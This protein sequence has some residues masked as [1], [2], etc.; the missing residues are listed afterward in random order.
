VAGLALLGLG[1][2]HAAER[3]PEY[4]GPLVAFLSVETVRGQVNHVRDGDTIELKGVPIRFGSLDC[5][6][7]NSVAG[8]RAAARMRRLVA[9]QSLTCYLNGRS[10]YE[11]KIGSCRLPDGR[12][13][14]A[15]M[16]AEGLCRRF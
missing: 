12:D 8:R 13:L 9:G 1:A 2:F 7:L 10:S 5:P 11:R 16:M 15:I 14:A 6:E 4:V 3:Y